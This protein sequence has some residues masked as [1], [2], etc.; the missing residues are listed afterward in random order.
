MAGSVSSPSLARAGGPRSRSDGRQLTVVPASLREEVIVSAGAFASLLA[1]LG[2][3]MMSR[4]NRE[5]G[6]G[7]C[8][9][10]EEG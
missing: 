9:L 8:W 1:Q 4:R 2:L 5:S 6:S 7:R 3:T 10:V